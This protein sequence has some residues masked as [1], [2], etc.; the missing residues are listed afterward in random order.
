MK[1]IAII[2]SVA[3]LAVILLSAVM[4]FAG[5]LSH[6]SF[7]TCTIIATLVWFIA[8][9]FWLAAKKGTSK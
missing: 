7:V 4:V 6:D 9:P 5:A 8:S 3:A 1:I 2:S